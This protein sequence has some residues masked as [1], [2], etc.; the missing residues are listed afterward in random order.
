M[1]TRRLSKSLQHARSARVER[2]TERTML[3]ARLQDQ[4]L[5]RRQL[6]HRCGMG[7]GMVGLAGVLDSAG[8]LMPAANAAPV[9]PLAP[10]P[11]HFTGRAQRVVH[12]FMNGG[13]SHV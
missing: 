6:L 3:P 2:R 10:R 7:F 9:N 11:P 13:P 5:T 1:S 8:M 4:L 12:L